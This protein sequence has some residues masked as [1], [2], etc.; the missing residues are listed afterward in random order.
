VRETPQGVILKVKVTPKARK[1]QILG[2]KEDELRIQVSA[3]PD[4]GEANQAVLKLL[5]ETLK[6]PRSSVILI[7]G[8]ASRQKTILIE[9]MELEQIRCLLP[10]QTEDG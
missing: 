2:W 1:T 3:P 9:G 5:A 4:K 8:P 6:R 10:P 7:S